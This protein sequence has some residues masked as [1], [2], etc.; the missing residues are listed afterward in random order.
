M[1]YYLVIVVVLILI[2]L[3]RFAG[4][5]RDWWPRDPFSS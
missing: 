4:V 2:L 3:A 5:G 1:M